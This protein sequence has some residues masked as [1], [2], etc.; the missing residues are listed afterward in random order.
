MNRVRTFHAKSMPEA[1]AQVKRAFGDDAVIL[2]TRTR[3]VSGLGG[4]WGR[5]RVEITAG[6]ADVASPAPRARRS[7]KAGQPVAPVSERRDKGVA[8]GPSGMSK[9]AGPVSNRSDA[10]ANELPDEMVAYCERLVQNDVARQLALQVVQQASDGTRGNLDAVEAEMRRLIAQMIPTVGG[11]EL[12]PGRAR[13]VA[14][15][16]PAGAGKTTTLAKLAAHFRLRERKEVAIVSLDMQRLAS[17][18]QLRRYAEII[19]VPFHSA[20]TIAA[21][22]EILHGLRDTDLVL[23]DTHGLGPR[24]Q[25]HFARLAALVR[26]TRPD[27]VHLVLPASL[28]AGAQAS[29]AR[30]FAPLGVSRVALTHLDEAV[31]LGVV[32]N[33]IDHLEWGISYL[34]DGQSVPSDIREAVAD[35]LAA[36]ICRAPARAQFLSQDKAV[37]RT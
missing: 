16:G 17:G 23:I 6:P 33:T 15:V 35:D 31:G 9:T 12:T 4:V 19:G 29:I 7:S 21:V 18:E 28:T 10:H 24:E 20:Q 3:E 37:N 22:K 25:A 36:D 1:L 32:L 2:G 14:F 5:N 26:A 13:R 11:I 8:P 34:S 30:T 27:E